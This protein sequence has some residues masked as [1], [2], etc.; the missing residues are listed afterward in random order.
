MVTSGLGYALCGLSD[1]L[2][3]VHHIAATG[4][5]AIN[6]ALPLWVPCATIFTVLYQ[7]IIISIVLSCLLLQCFWPVASYQVKLFLCL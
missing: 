6:G 4:F 3:M 5:L 1:Y 2:K 7:P